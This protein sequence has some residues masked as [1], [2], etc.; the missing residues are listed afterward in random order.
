MPNIIVAI[1]THNNVVCMCD[2]TKNQNIIF[3]PECKNA[4]IFRKSL[5]NAYAYRRAEYR[6][7]LILPLGSTT[8]DYLY[9][10]NKMKLMIIRTI[11][12]DVF[13]LFA[14]ANRKLKPGKQKQQQLCNF[15][16]P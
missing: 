1:R 6:S 10:I 2:E 16:N 8:I 15:E 7:S 3:G 5:S 12:H 11:E 4:T 9:T 14:Y 13:Y